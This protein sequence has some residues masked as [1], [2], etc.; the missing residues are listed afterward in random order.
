MAIS[1]VIFGI[2][3]WD[4]FKRDVATIGLAQLDFSQ[5]NLFGKYAW[6]CQSEEIELYSSTISDLLEMLEAI[7]TIVDERTIQAIES[8]YFAVLNVDAIGDRN[9]SRQSKNYGKGPND[10]QLDDD[11]QRD[12]DLAGS[13]SPSRVKEI[14]GCFEAFDVAVLEPFFEKIKENGKE[15]HQRFDDFDEMKIYLDDVKDI[16]GYAS[17]NELGMVIFM[18]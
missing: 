12:S 9:S 14:A 13:I 7:V 1:Y 10:L 18:L 17:S 3:R 5:A 4:E 6:G 15:G 2:E 11:F 16:V 8:T